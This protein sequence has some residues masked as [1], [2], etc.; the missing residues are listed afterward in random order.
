MLHGNTAAVDYRLLG[1]IKEKVLRLIADVASRRASCTPQMAAHYRVAFN[2]DG[3]RHHFSVYRK[4][5]SFL[6]H[7]DADGR[8]GFVFLRR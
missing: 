4:H 5:L 2:A 7:A 8:K 1:A 6:F 3:I